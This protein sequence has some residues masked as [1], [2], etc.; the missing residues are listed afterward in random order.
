MFKGELGA[1]YRLCFHGA[2]VAHYHREILAG[3]DM[4]GT[5][6]GL[7][8]CSQSAGACASLLDPAQTLNHNTAFQEPILALHSFQCLPQRQAKASLI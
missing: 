1:S 4:E 7:P 2:V 3:C 8:Q 6:V 5:A